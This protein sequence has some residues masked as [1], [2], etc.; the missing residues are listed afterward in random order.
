MNEAQLI[1]AAIREA[2]SPGIWSIM[3]V[4][5]NAVLAL[6]A[7]LA[8]IYARSQLSQF[9][10]QSELGQKQF[11]AA[12]KQVE[13]AEAQVK[14]AEIATIA[15]LDR[16][17]EN[18]YAQSRAELKKFID[19]VDGEL[20]KDAEYKP[21]RGEDRTNYR[22]KTFHLRLHEMRES[23]DSRYVTITAIVGHFETV[24][25]FVN[26]EYL[27]FED[28]YDL[29]QGSILF[30]DDALGEHIQWEA[31]ENERKG[32]PP[33]LYKNLRSLIAMTKERKNSS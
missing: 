13:A 16:D 32:N 11:E 21:K 25:M 5:F 15:G 24:G 10:K 33:G 1:A 30:V 8:L 12:N 27:K 7:I 14:Q 9:K 29:Y 19:E 31:D 18:T 26:K 17:F 4:I 20:E 2:A 3:A 22:K 23:G 28:I 6:T